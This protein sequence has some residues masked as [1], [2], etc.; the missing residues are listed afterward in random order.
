LWEHKRSHFSCFLKAGE[1]VFLFPHTHKCFF[2]P[3]Q[4][5]L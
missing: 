3:S 1:T 5:L 2:K 4:C